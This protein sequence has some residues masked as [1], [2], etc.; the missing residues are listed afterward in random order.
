[1]QLQRLKSPKICPLQAGDAGEPMV[2]FQSKSNGLRTRR[3]DD[4]S[5]SLSPKA[6]ENQCPS[7]KTGRQDRA[8]SPLLSFLFYSGFKGLEEETLPHQGGQ[9]ALVSPPIQM[10]ISSRSIL[11]DTQNNVEPNIWVPC[12][13]VKLTDKINHNSS[14]ISKLE[15][16]HSIYLGYKS[17]QV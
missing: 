15:T 17:H 1:M 5:S 6:G 9:S 3:T 12:G 16:S 8:N 11:T 2:Q 7:S 14:L 4:V 13:L 10:L